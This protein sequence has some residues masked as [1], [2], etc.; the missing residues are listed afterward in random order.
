MKP[1]Q[2]LPFVWRITAAAIL[3]GAAILRFYDLEDVPLP[4]ADEVVAAVDI[5]SIVLTG[6]HFDR[7]PADLLAY[8]TPLIDGRFA[9]Y[10]FV[11]ARVADF[12]LVSAF[13]GVLTVALMLWLGRELGSR[14]LGVGAAGALAIMPWHIYFSRIF[15]PASE[16]LCLTVLMICLAMATLRRQSTWLAVATGAA[17]AGTMY[18]YPVGLVSTP[19][20]LCL[21]AAYRSAELA[22]YG[23]RRLALAGLG[24]GTIVLV[25]YFVAHLLVVASTTA[26]V[27]SVIASKMIWNHELAPWALVRLFASNWSS[28]YT[29]Q[30]ILL[31]GDPNVA[32]SIQVI[33][34]VGWC[35]GSLGIVGAA[36]A[37]A[38]R[39]RTDYLLLGLA[40]TFPIADA[41]T[42]FDARGNSVR[43]ILGSVVWALLAGLA[44]LETP[45]ILPTVSKHA[46]AA[47]VG[48]GLSVQA[49]LFTGYYFGPYSERNAYAFETGYSQIYSALAQRG[50]VEVPITLHAGYE[51]DV[52]LE[53]FSGYRL[54]PTQTVLACSPLPFDVSHYTV[55]PRIFI[56]REDRGFSADRQCTDQSSLIAHDEIELRSVE[57]RPYEPSSRK[58][59]LIAEFSNDPQ[60]DYYTAV[61]FVHY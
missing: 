35:L 12:R 13:F 57:Q 52:L 16:Y 30:F 14:R 49:L 39:S 60:D 33:G 28:Y 59:D 55:L 29:P 22:R 48:A 7:S 4:F 58:I 15:F 51:R 24:M 21:V 6:R 23:V 40:L 53:Y 8:I 54:A 61:Y 19:I 9:I 44:L 25:P 45:R 56:V 50:L 36:I 41:L 47:A 27:N 38:R 5:R 26:I 10:Y 17:A 32:Q 2:R 46:F 31:S 11:G 37:V 20:V 42:Y 34:Q 1:R 18:L 3:V 43:G